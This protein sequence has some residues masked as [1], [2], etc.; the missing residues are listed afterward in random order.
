MK[1]FFVLFEFF[2]RNPKGAFKKSLDFRIMAVIGD[3]SNYEI[4]Q[5]ISVTFKVR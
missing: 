2:V 3:E 1:T 4:F 5:I